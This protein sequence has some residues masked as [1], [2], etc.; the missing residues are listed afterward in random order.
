MR[1]YRLV[2]IFLVALAAVSCGLIKTVYNN[3]PE[4]MHWWLDDYFDFTPVQ[5]EQLKPALHALH[6]WH[7]QTQLALY[8]EML[9]KIQS[10]LSREKLEASAVCESIIAIQNGMRTIQLESSPIIIEIAPM[11]SA[12]QLSYFQ[13]M[14]QKR[15]L[16]W[17]SEWL[18]DTRE[19]QL[20]ARL[21]KTIG[22]AEKL[23]GGLNQL[24]KSMLKQKLLAANYKP[25]MS[26]TEILRRN[27]DALQLVTALNQ[28]N[29]D[30]IDKDQAQQLLK[31]GFERL[32]N[33]PNTVYQ[34]Y[35]EHIKL[36]SCEMIA[37][38]HTTTDNK[39]K[40]HAQEWLENLILQLSSLIP[41]KG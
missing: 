9:Q 11:L 41:N 13:K 36:H 5:S 39:Q 17:K 20:E 19:E 4:A 7:R 15:A 2:I 10:D 23:Y 31:Q 14:L 38:L 29:Q 28:K 6:D 8:I 32:H 1:S 12:K 37:D 40:K 30:R 21:K 35:A 18:Q 33:S 34:Q 24:Q 22:Y 27:Q 26:Y 3:A 16:K 25:E